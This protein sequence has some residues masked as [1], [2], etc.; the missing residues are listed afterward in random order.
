MENSKLKEVNDA[1]VQRYYGEA[2]QERFLNDL[3]KGSTYVKAIGVGVGVAGAMT[4]QPELVAAGSAIYSWGGRMEDVGTG[5]E[6]V[7]DLSKKDFQ[8][9]ILETTTYGAGRILEKASDYQK[10]PEI[11][12][13]LFNYSKDKILDTYKENIKQ[14]KSD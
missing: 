12:K 14:Q 13:L 7:K 9:A 4:G 5:I 11:N 2:G 10:V 8:G 6:I 3:E 1:F